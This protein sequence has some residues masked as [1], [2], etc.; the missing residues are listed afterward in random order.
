MQ[1]GLSTE[2]QHAWFEMVTE[3]LTKIPSSG[4]CCCVYRHAGTISA[5]WFS[6]F[7]G[8]WICRCNIHSR[9]PA[10]VLC[11]IWHFHGSAEEG[12]QSS[13]IC[14]IYWYA[15]TYFQYT[16]LV[17]ILNI[18]FILKLHILKEFIVIKTINELKKN[19]ISQNLTE[20]SQADFFIPVKWIPYKTSH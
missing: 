4:I 6:W 3:I 18:S 11:K 15:C 10:G 2:V 7:E 9:H 13:G 1:H 20:L 8:T 17:P 5:A 12:F 19:T 14:H 16:V